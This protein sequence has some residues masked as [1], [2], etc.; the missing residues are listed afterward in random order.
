MSLQ[1]AIPLTRDY[2]S[3]RS[4]MRLIE[5]PWFIFIAALPWD[6]LPADLGLCEKSFIS[7]NA[8]SNW[9]MPLESRARPF[10]SRLSRANRNHSPSRYAT[11]RPPPR[12]PSFVPTAIFFHLLLSCSRRISASRA[13]NDWRRIEYRR[14]EGR[15]LYL[16]ARWIYLANCLALYTTPRVQTSVSSLKF[17]WRDRSLCPRICTRL[18]SLL[19]LLRHVSPCPSISDL[20]E[21]SKIFQ[22][23]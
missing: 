7:N 23:S 19:M 13:R 17:T 20:C 9:I 11:R 1:G 18:F 4:L 21:S 15:R 10:I 2:F 12:S 6:L 22:T 8:K 16:R 5:R 14:D 3:E